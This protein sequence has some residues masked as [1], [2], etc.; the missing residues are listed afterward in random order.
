[1]IP[2]KNLLNEKDTSAEVKDAILAA[3]RNSSAMAGAKRVLDAWRALAEANGMASVLQAAVLESIEC[4]TNVV[5]QLHA[6]EVAVRA[7]VDIT[8]AERR[9]YK[10]QCEARKEEVKPLFNR[11]AGELLSLVEKNKAIEVAIS[12]FS[13]ARDASRER[14]KAAGFT[15]AEIE[16]V[17]IKPTTEDLAAWRRELDLNNERQAVL[18]KFLKSGP[19][20]PEQILDGVKA[21]A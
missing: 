17:G 14:Y 2:I 15:S 13:A 19:E 7:Q 8:L 4:G 6:Y 12:R 3:S 9:A 10:V 21:E 5:D 18:D 11:C 1:M 16:A 20:Y